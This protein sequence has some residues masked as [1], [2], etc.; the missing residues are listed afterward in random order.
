MVGLMQAQAV[1]RNRGDKDN[2]EVDD[3]KGEF[4]IAVDP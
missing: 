3:K 2:K 4:L 1:G